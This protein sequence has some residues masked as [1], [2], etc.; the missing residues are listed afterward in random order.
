MTGPGENMGL[1]QPETASGPEPV[2]GRHLTEHDV[3][4]SIAND[5]RDGR[6]PRETSQ[7]PGDRE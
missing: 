5:E 3:M 6:A 4:D 7:S 2:D 1:K